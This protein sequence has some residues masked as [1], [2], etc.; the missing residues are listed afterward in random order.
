MT[1]I[2]ARLPD[3]L[4]GAWMPQPDNV[5][6]SRAELVRHAIE[7]YLEDL[8]LTVALARLHDPAELVLD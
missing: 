2:T 1:R 6:E 8:D 3:A 7:R 5:T 4:V